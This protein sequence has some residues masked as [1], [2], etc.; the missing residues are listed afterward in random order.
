MPAS[1]CNIPSIAQAYS[2][3]VTVVPRKPL[4]YLTIWPAGQPRPLVSTLNSFDGRI[5]ANA[6]IVPAGLSGAISVFA[7]DDTDVLADINGYFVPAATAGA[8]Q[9]LPVKP[10]RA[11]DTRTAGPTISANTS[12]SFNIAASGCGVPGNAAAFSLNI[13]AVPQGPLQYLTAWPTGFNQPNVSTLNS[14]AGTV[15]ANAALVPAGSGGS[16]SIYVTDKTDVI[17]DVNGYFGQ[18]ASGMQFYAIPPCRVMDTR[19]PLG[20]LG[21]PSLGAAVVRNIPVVDSSCAVPSN[22]QAYSMNATVVPH[23]SLQYLTLWG[24]NQAQPNVSTLNSFTGAVVANAAI[25]PTTSG[26]IN[27]FVTN[28]TDLI[29]DSNGYFAP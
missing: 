11:A 3:N 27:A 12:R 2:V 14:F 20:P 13:T 1:A 9:F 29:L 17:L 4:S 25:V 16:V 8:L 18:P 22:A 10:C 24:T 6:A 5:V 7:T 21:G 28:F 23:E 15:V 26:S 19:N